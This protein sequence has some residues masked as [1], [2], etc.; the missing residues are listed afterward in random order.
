MSTAGVVATVVVK[1]QKKPPPVGGIASILPASLSAAGTSTISGLCG[2][3]YVSTYQIA[4]DSP[5]ALMLMDEPDA[6]PVVQNLIL[7]LDALPSGP[8]SVV[9]L[10][11]IVAAFTTVP[12]ITD[13]LTSFGFEDPSWTTYIGTTIR[14][15]HGD[16]HAGNILISEGIPVL[17]DFDNQAIAS[18]LTDPAALLFGYVFHPESPLRIGRIGSWPSEDQCSQFLDADFMS[19]CP[20]PSLI[21]ECLEWLKER[22]TSD[23]EV[24]GIVLAFACKTAKFPDIKADTA[25]TTRVRALIEWALQGLS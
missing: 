7:N 11:D 14:A 16:L 18:Q 13:V 17:I 21:A 4:G 12:Q 23:R 25:A 22:T 8:E 1:V 2:G 5:V 9:Q 6:V 19:G 15:Q 3:S 20:R 24:R 10:S